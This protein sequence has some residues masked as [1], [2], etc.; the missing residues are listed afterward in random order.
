M[1][2]ATSTNIKNRFGEYLDNSAIEPILIKKS[3]RPVAVMVSMR[4]YERLM[5]IE[6]EYWAGKALAAEESGYMGVE[7]SMKLLQSGN[8]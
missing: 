3:G 7:E 6:D 4:E 2:I 5:A 8:E 1:K